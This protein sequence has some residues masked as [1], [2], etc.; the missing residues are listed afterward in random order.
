MVRRSSLSVSALVGEK[1]QEGSGILLIWI[2]L[3]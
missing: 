1:V 3:A 2:P